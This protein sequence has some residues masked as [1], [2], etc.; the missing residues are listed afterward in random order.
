MEDTKNYSNIEEA[1]EDNL[2]DTSK[3]MDA[4]HEETKL[5]TS[6]GEF[7]DKINEEFVKIETIKKRSKPKKT[8]SDKMMGSE[9]GLE[10]R[11]CVEEVLDNSVELVKKQDEEYVK[12]ENCNVDFVNKNSLLVHKKKCHKKK[13]PRVRPKN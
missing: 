4:K 8:N 11:S 10:V 5:K 12:C 7:I 2:K 9:G 1:K 6:E 3:K 13:L